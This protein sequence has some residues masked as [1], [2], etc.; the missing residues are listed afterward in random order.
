M[1]KT[2]VTLLVLSPLMVF[3]LALYAIALLAL[4][5]AYQLN[6]RAISRF[7]RFPA[8]VFY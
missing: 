1:K 6:R 5:V 2:K 7:Y 8:R 3:I 4:G